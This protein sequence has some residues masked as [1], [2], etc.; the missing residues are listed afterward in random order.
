LP[1]VKVKRFRLISLIM[2]VSKQPGINSAVWLLKFTFMKN[3][4]VK[5]GKL[6]K[7]N[8]KICGSSS[9]GAAESRLELKHM[10]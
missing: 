9:K 4:L 5:R 10:F 3:I 8:Y 2:E 1:E 6:K 7:E